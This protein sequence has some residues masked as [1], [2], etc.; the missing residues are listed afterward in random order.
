MSESIPTQV[1]ITVPT[2][3]PGE[4]GGVPN[5]S[6]GTEQI[7]GQAVTESKLAPA[8]IKKL[9]PTAWVPVEGY[10]PKVEATPG[11][12]ARLEQNEEIVQLRGGL[13]VKAG[14]VVG[15]EKIFT[16]PA[17]FRPTI[18]NVIV[19]AAATPGASALLLQINFQQSGN[20]AIEIGSLEDVAELSVAGIRY[21]LVQ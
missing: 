1:P 15:L 4:P 14:E 6:V 5:N 11:V 7:R 18:H 10:S 19:V 21:A 3:T 9:N 12:E 17:Q 16:M 2:G 8:V 20:V 13:K